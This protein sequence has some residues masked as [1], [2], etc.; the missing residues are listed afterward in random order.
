VSVPY[1][2]GLGP[3]SYV[4]AGRAAACLWRL[5]RDVFL[6]GAT[7]AYLAIAEISKG[8]LHFY[9]IMIERSS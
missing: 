7:L 6:I 3:R 2:F 5:L 8:I 1:I 9:R 4:L